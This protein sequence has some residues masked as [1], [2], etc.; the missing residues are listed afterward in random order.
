MQHLVQCFGREDYF[1]SSLDEVANV[2]VCI[3]G[4]VHHMCIQPGFGREECPGLY[5]IHGVAQCNLY[6]AKA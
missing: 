3:C 6:C 5:T 1:D 4:C 2:S